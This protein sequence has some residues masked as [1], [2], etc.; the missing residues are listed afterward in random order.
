MAKWSHCACLSERA[1]QKASNKY[2]QVN[3]GGNQ[4]VFVATDL[5]TFYVVSVKKGSVMP[6]RRA[7]MAYSLAPLS[8]I[9]CEGLSGS[10]FAASADPDIDLRFDRIAVLVTASKDFKSFVEKMLQVQTA[11]PTSK[12]GE[13]ENSTTTTANA[14]NSEAVV[15][16]C[17]EKMQHFAVEE[18]KNAGFMVIDRD[19]TS[20]DGEDKTATHVNLA[21][22]KASA[23]LTITLGAFARAKRSADRRRRGTNSGANCA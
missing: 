14:P 11:Q 15:E 12:E 4:N 19:F 3:A 13:K 21:S 7:F 9:I 2:S 6:T 1:L 10:A 20:S 23:L 18:L 16:A 17:V 22:L 8:L 5:F